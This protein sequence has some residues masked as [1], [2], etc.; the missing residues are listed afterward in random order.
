[1]SNSLFRKKL[2]GGLNSMD[3]EEYI[4]NLEHEIES[5]KVL[6]QKEKN[7]LLKKVEQY[8]ENSTAGTLDSEL[9]KQAEEM[10]Q[11]LEQ[12]KKEK[13][14]LREANS[15]LEKEKDNL[16]GLIRK[17]ENSQSG[18]SNG[19]EKQ[20]IRLQQEN[21]ELKKQIRKQEEEISEQKNR[22]RSEGTTEEKQADTDVL[23]DYSTVSKIIEDANRNADAIREE[24]KEDAARILAEA[25]KEVERKKVKIASKVNSQ[26]EEKGIQLMAAKYKIEQYVKE[27][28]SLQQGMYTLYSRMNNLVNDMPVRLDDYWEGEHYEMLES[29]RLLGNKKEKSEGKTDQEDKTVKE[30]ESAGKTEQ[31]DSG[32]TVK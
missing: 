30:K 17:A 15:L 12:L 20:L 10:Q 19:W 1:M 11:Q 16:E 22:I 21:D 32:H 28:D 18:D 29:R 4:R 25:D 8:E 7:E 3:V 31:K 14:E 26:L 6:H 24:A 9:H 2:F 5:V 13:E 27:I 23:F